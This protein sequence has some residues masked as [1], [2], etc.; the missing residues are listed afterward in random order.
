VLI[1]EISCL[2]SIIGSI[3]TSLFSIGV[4]IHNIR[5]GFRWRV[6]ACPI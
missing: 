2:K 3:W 5:A 6:R 4:V 1:W